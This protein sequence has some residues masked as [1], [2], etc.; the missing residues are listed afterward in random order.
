MTPIRLMPFGQVDPDAIFEV[1]KSVPFR[2]VVVIGITEGGELYITSTTTKLS[3]VNAL[4]DIGKISI[5]G[6]MSPETY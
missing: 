4:I 3:D 1:A 2:D 5:V 6:Q